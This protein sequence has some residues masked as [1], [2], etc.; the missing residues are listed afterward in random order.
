MNSSS[1][2]GRAYR[3]LLAA[4]KTFHG[5]M[6]P[7]DKYRL[8]PSGAARNAGELS[9]FLF[10]H[11]AQD[12]VRTLANELNE[13]RHRVARLAAWVQVLEAYDDDGTMALLGEFVS[14][15][16]E[17]CLLTPYSIKQ[18]LILSACRALE[19]SAQHAK[20]P[21]TPDEA[22]GRHVL[23]ALAMGHATGEKLMSSIAQLDSDE[24]QQATGN[25]RHRATHRRPPG[26]ELDIH[27]NMRRTPEP[28]GTT[29]YDVSVAFPISLAV[30][31]QPL[32]E[33]HRRAT[34]AF[35]KLWA[36]IKDVEQ[37]LAAAAEAGASE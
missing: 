28:D 9:L 4:D 19:H 32:L 6:V 16:A 13:W 7:F 22:M 23:V 1:R 5:D 29:T 24:L 3:D 14:P 33:E 26:L 18:R 11:M 37:E 8:N 35:K 17:C 27:R 10:E 20:T 21:H 36:V 31:V 34:A 25:Y 15:V 12:L 30:I 2:H